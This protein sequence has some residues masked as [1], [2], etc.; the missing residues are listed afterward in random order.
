[1]NSKI[2][3]QFCCYTISFLFAYTGTAKLLSLS[4]FERTL[5]H[6]PIVRSM[7]LVPAIL[8]PL[9]EMILAIVLLVESRQLLALVTSCFLLIGFTAYIGI[10]LLFQ[11]QLPCSCGGVIASM[12]WGQ[13]LVFNLF[14]I[15]I[16]FAGI[17]LCMHQNRG[18][19]KPA[20]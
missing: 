7:G 14:F 4:E 20:E 17:K 19:R 10:S 12:S 3:I 11:T 15:V 8:I 13:H 5:S 2:L 16:A 6:I 18:S 1:M 9:L